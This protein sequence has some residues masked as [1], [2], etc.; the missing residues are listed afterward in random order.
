[1]YILS[2]TTKSDYVIVII[3]SV[4]YTSMEDLNKF[5]INNN[6]KKYVV[7]WSHLTFSIT[8]EQNYLQNF[9]PNRWFWFT[10]KPH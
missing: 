6:F 1:M 5:L 7:V 3:H 8:Y 9:L 4:A 10:Y 2:T